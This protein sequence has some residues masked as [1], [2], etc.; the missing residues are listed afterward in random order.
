MN[1]KILG[2]LSKVDLRE[3]WA[4]EA[5]DFT[6]WLAQLDNSSLLGQAIGMDLELETQEK[7]VGPF[8]A[9]ILCK[10]T[11]TDNWVLIENQFHCRRSRGLRSSRRDRKDFRGFL[12]VSIPSS[13]LTVL[14]TQ[15]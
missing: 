9:D 7:K 10:E 4:S 1:T 15:R 14:Q 13:C 3:A 2:K 12:E 11:A 8:R 6:P 5:G